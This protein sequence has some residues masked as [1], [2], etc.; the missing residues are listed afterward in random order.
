MMSEMHPCY[1]HLRQVTTVGK[2]HCQDCSFT[3]LSAEK[4]R[5]ISII[6]RSYMLHSPQHS[7]LLAG[8]ARNIPVYRQTA[9][10]PSSLTDAAA[11]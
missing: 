11:C 8:T 1:R 5:Q 10:F 4:Q 7:R 3:E 2:G 6:N 9:E